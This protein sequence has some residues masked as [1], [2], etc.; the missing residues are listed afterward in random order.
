MILFAIGVLLG[1]GASWL[2]THKYYV[3]AGNEQRTELENLKEGLKPNNT[4]GN[5]ERL[6]AE[7]AWDETQV[8]N[9][10][11]WICQTDNTYQIHLGDSSQAYSE[12]WT[13]VYPDKTA[14]ACPVYLKIGSAVIKELTF[15]YMDGY[16]IFVPMTE[17]RPS[18]VGANQ[19]EFFWNLNSLKV[20]V[21]RVIG[22]YY[23]YENL[24]GIARMSSVEIVE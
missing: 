17:V 11:V 24:E 22:K 8:D 18:T 14:T 6:L 20:K 15:I 10:E 5:F 4:L 1:A 2:I 3:K 9:E 16:R 7:G 13:T 12:R 19:I 21:C 23:I